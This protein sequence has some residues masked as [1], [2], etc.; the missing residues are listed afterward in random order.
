MHIETVLSISSSSGRMEK[1]TLKLMPLIQFISSQ[2]IRTV[3]SKKLRILWPGREIK[4]IPHQLET[5][6]KQTAQWSHYCSRVQFAQKN[7]KK[8]KTKPSLFLS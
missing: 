7:S 5:R 3:I 4:R 2:G 6:E 1:I 8:N